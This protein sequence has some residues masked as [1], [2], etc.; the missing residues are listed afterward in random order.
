MHK[1]H[2]LITTIKHL[3]FI[4]ASALS[5]SATSKESIELPIMLNLGLGLGE[6]KANTPV[7]PAGQKLYA[8]KFDIKGAV[9]PETIELFKD[10]L[11]KKL[12]KWLSKSGIAYSPGYFP[13][14]IYFTDSNEGEADVFGFNYGPSIGAGIG[15]DMFTL[16][17]NLGL[18]LTYLYMDTPLFDDNH[19]FSA[20]ASA[21]YYL[22]FKPIKYLHFQIG[23]THNWNI[24]NELSNGEEL[25]E[26]T[27]TYAMLHFR[28][29]ITMNFEF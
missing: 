21:D 8:L 14:A 6:V 20:G 4:F 18:G 27:E 29:P 25:S 13:N 7:I 12:P 2:K 10:K 15:N 9:E 5:F 23:R 3:V 16:G 1:R 19:Y 26:F 28:F 11:P 24:T 17:A 22:K